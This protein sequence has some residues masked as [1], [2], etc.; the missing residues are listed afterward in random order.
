MV[1]TTAGDSDLVAGFRL[2]RLLG[3]HERAEVHLGVSRRV[4][5]TDEP[6]RA[7]VAIKIY[8]DFT[9][10]A[11]I[12]R[13]IT[14]LERAAGAHVVPL[15]DVARAPTGRLCLVLERVPGMSLAR[16]LETRASISVGEAVTVLAPLVATLARIHRSHVAHGG[17]R[18]TN[19][20]FSDDGAPVLVGFGN[21]RLIDDEETVTPHEGDKL[22]L[23]DLRALRSLIEQT[24]HSS[25]SS[26]AVRST[27]HSLDGVD[28]S[29]PTWA[30]AW[31]DV[32]FGLA[33]PLPVDI[34][35]GMR[36]TEGSTGASGLLHASADDAEVT[37]RRERRPRRRGVARGSSAVVSGL[38]AG[39]HSLV[40]ALRR[41]RRRFWAV[42]AIAVAGVVA[43]TT[44]SPTAL[45]TFGGRQGDPDK[46]LLGES[47]SR[48]AP[49]SA[50]DPARGE[51]DPRAQSIAGDEAIVGDDPVAALPILLGERERCLRE[52]SIL[53]L[54]GVDHPDSPLMRA[55]RAF[56]DAAQSQD[57]DTRPETA[58]M[59]PAGTMHV[60][61]R[62]GAASLLAA[63]V[64]DALLPDSNEQPASILLMKGEAGWR[65]REIF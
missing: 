27:L 15:L 53:C 23:S 10:E 43:L 26:E 1:F 47:R 61:E 55:D 60:V 49:Q 41:V 33:E 21:A 2:V 44:L 62:L 35:R 42:T 25:G 63:A 11:S 6:R 64:P 59:P 39:A 3:R 22:R 17:V 65:L 40:T 7:P 38:G 58:L 36:Q 28:L 8:S 9:T 45:E 12:N 50:D 48:I 14:A 51:A 18:S 37:A 31:L 4:A 52:L 32:L 19:V 54:D 30:D 16:L 29:A 5:N 20:L 34:G 57:E 56:I 46:T 13:E 24:L